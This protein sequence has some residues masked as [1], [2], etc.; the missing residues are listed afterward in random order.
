MIFFQCVNNPNDSFKPHELILQCWKNLWEFFQVNRMGNCE[1]VDYQ[2][3]G[4]V[5]LTQS[6]LRDR[7]NI[8]VLR[9]VKCDA[10]EI[11]ASFL[12]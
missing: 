2:K 10:Q 8:C 6:V 5:T 3:V 11:E 9:V 12:L 1:M 4:R 7:K